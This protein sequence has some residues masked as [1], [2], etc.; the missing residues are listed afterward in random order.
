[1]EAKKSKKADLES[2]RIL[3]FEVGLTVSILLAILAFEWKSPAGINTSLIAEL[4]NN[5]GTIELPP[6]TTDPKE[7]VKPEPPKVVISEKII[8]V[9]NNVEPNYNTDIFEEPKDAY[10]PPVIR[11]EEKE[12]DEPYVSVE[13][14]P[15]FDKGDANHFRNTYVIPNIR[16]PQEAIDNGVIGVALVEF[17]VERD[18]RVTNVKV[19][20]KIDKSL[21]REAIRVVSSSPRWEPGINNGVKV[22][23]KFVIPIKFVLNN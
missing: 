2:K 21:E 3:F 6:I 5:N 4:G 10:V 13:E 15:T 1:M 7:M 19:L 20:N 11:I 14:M 9:D 8:V 12:V 16:Y 18:G 17:V 22:R 23:V